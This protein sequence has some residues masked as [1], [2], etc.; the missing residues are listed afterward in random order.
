M[1]F[2]K[3]PDGLEKFRKINSLLKELSDRLYRKE[4]KVYR[5]YLYS[6]V[7]KEFD[8][9]FMIEADLLRMNDFW[10]EVKAVYQHIR[11]QNGNRW[12]SL[13]LSCLMVQK[14]KGRSRHES[15]ILCR[16]NHDS[17]LLEITVR[18]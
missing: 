11:N 17:F 12:T 3:D 8:D 1:L 13:E 15:S 6:G 7:D 2:R 4:A 10:C 14:V 18:L 16:Q 5:H 9:D